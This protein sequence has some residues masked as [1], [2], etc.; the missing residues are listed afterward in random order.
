MK[1]ILY[2]AALLFA[3]TQISAQSVPFLN[4]N[5]D[6]YSHSMGGT[7]LTLEN[8]A[9]TMSNNS[10]AMVFS[11]NK[12]HFGGSYN[13]W[14]PDFMN[15][16]NIGFAAYGK[17]GKLA[18]GIG[19]KMFGY[20]A[21]DVINSQ[22]AP[23]GTF[24]PKEMAIEGAFA[25]RISENFSAGINIRS[26]SSKLAK[27]AS[28]SSMGADVTVTYHKENLTVAA[29][30]TNIGGDIDYGSGATYALPSMAKVG[31]GYT[32]D[33]EKS[34]LNL[35]VEGDLLLDKSEI[36]AALGAEYAYNNMFKARA[37]Y[38]MG[39]DE[40]IPSY[41]SVGFGLKFKTINLDAAYIFGGGE[42]S[43]LNGSFG[44]ALGL[45]F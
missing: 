5:A 25:Y 7:T 9:F 1:K 8:N 12:Y 38:H 34:R 6:P 17:F 43:T 26:I 32:F 21:Y 37:G 31:A 36:M 15:N 24:T 18:V 19:G 16:Q 3:T 13:T 2:I 27:E 20:Q 35:N 4:I 44:L 22:G 42:N 41:G 45:R 29:A 10:S 23:N 33:M 30:V 39:S 28:A 14:Q 40:A 11:E